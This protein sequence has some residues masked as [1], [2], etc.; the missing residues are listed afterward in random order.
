MTCLDKKLIIILAIVK[1]KGASVYE[2]TY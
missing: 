1:L 2:K